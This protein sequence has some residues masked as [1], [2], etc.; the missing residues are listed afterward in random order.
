M[1]PSSTSSSPRVLSLIATIIIFF[2]ISITLSCH[3]CVADH[4]RD[5]HYT[6]EQEIEEQQGEGRSIGAYNGDNHYYHHHGFEAYP[7]SSFGMAAHDG[8]DDD[9]HSMDL[10]KLT[11][12][13]LS[14]KTTEKVGATSSS[15]SSSSSAHRVQVEDFREYAGGNDDTKMF[16]KAWEAACSTKGS[17]VQLVVPAKNSYTVGPITFSGPCKSSSLTVEIAG[18]IQAS[19]DR[20][21]YKEDTSHWLLFEGVQN[22]VVQGGGTIDG[23]GNVWWQNS[24]K[25][26]KALPCTK[27]PTAVTF[28]KCN[29]LGVR[30]LRIQNA[31][32][33]HLTFQACTNVQAANLAV[34]SPEKSPNTDGIH[35]TGTKNIRISGAVI[36]TGDDCI[37]IVS[38]SQNVEATGITC[39]PGHGISIGSLGA[40]NSQ[41]H[42]SGVTVDG[43][44]FSGS[45]NGLRIKTWQ[46]GSGS[47]SNFRFQNIVMDNVEN[48]IIIDQNYCDQDKPCKE[49]KSAVQIKN[50][51]Y[52]NVKGTSASEVAIKLDCSK[53]F[54]CQGVVLQDVHLVRQGSQED[55]GARAVCSNV[56]LSEVGAVSPSCS[57]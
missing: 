2:Y 24:C 20:S 55:K 42:V 12:D 35:V 38:G 19:G 13:V 34:K 33:M 44:R 47:A 51:V 8:D 16:E 5:H 21:D 31:Q 32:Q 26:N 53:S 52:K 48:P 36:G 9:A 23:N 49:Q 18:T 29:N 22:L 41:A 3:H 4:H 54:P 45:T 39:G 17:A 37:S 10:V 43:A 7:S 56:K 28:S 46:G 27:A 57:H 6:I 50:V 11:S 14:F 25:V 15:S 30:N 40:H 1:A